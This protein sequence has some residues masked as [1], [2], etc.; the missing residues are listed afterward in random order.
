MTGQNTQKVPLYW[1]KVGE[2]SQNYS[3]CPFK[4]LVG[5][6]LTKG[7]SHIMLSIYFEQV[8]HDTSFASLMLINY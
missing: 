5:D 3:T 8:G 7:T 2:W 6:V 1:G 4:I